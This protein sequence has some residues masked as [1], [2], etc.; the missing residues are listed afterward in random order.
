MQPL[1][2]IK[3]GPFDTDGLPKVELVSLGDWDLENFPNGFR[4]AEFNPAWIHAKDEEIKSLK[5]K[6][7]TMTADRDAEKSMKA[8]ARM[9]RDE[10]TKR[11]LMNKG[12]L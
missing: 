7:A 1:F 9:Q 10:I 3:Y 2:E 5:L 12:N 4:F 8:K 11:F 6:L